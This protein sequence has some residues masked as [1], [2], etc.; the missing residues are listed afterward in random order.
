[1]VGW[2]GKW[3][4]GRGCIKYIDHFKIIKYKKFDFVFVVFLYAVLV[5]C[6]FVF[7]SLQEILEVHFIHWYSL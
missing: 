5:L 3:E 2:K 4:K 6:L 1:M 7:I